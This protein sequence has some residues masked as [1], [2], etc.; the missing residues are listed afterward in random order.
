[1]G[2]PRVI[3]EIREYGDFTAAIR[4]WIL[5]LD[6]TY[7]CIDE[8]AGLQDR[9]L[10]KLIQKS[11]VRNFGPGTLSCVLGALGLKLILV[12]DTEKLAKLRPRYL[13]RKK[14]AC[15]RMLAIKRHNTLRFNAKLAQLLAHRRALLLA[16]SR[17][18]AIARKAAQIRWQNGHTPPLVR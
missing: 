14:H 8:I 6:T 17:R 11:P 2:E 3:A 9:Y 13:P 4:K 15:E 12:I 7:E 18:K 16:P 10:S 5:E 1:M